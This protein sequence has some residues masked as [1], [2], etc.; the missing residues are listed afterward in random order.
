MVALAALN[1]P[2]TV[3]I[4][5]I[6]ILMSIVL[7]H[8]LAHCLAAL[9]YGIRTRDITLFI[10]G[11][12]ARIDGIERMTPRQEFFVTVAGPLSNLVPAILMVLFGLVQVPA[13]NEPMT[14]LTHICFINF[15]LGIFN[16]LPAFPMDGGRILRSGLQM[17]GVGSANTITL[18]TSRAV[19][20]L[21]LF[22]GIVN[23]APSFL[24]IALFVF[25]AAPAELG[26][27]R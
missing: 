3:A 8:E 2:L 12:V 22:V 19:G 6:T 14:L 21:L 24:L 23:L 26:R 1:Q 10:L 11:G 7:W 27:K 25:L 16:L 13:E 4:V 17:L 15:L 18:W 5:N 20:A 9:S